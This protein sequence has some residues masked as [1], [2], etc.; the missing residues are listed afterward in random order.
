MK[1]VKYALIL[2]LS[3]LCQA[4]Q[5][6]STP[7]AVPDVHASTQG[8]STTQTIQDFNSDP[9]VHKLSVK[10]NWT[11]R[12][13]G[14]SSAEAVLLSA[15]SA[16]PLIAQICRQ[17]E[18]GAV[19]EVNETSSQTNSSCFTG[20]QYSNGRL[21][22]CSRSEGTNN[23]TVIHKVTCGH[24]AV[25]LAGRTDRCEGRV[26]LW[27]SG[28]WGTVC[29]DQWDLRDADVACAQL[30]C[31]YALD[32]TGQGGAV[33]AG[34]GPIHLDEVN[35]TGEE[36]NL[37]ACPAAGGE[38]D[39]GHK[40]DAGIV[41]S[42]KRDVRLSGGLD[43][44]SG[45][46]EVHRNGSWGTVCDNCWNGRLASI[47]CSML[48]C[49]TRPQK[50]S[51]FSPPLK[52]NSGALYFY[53][54]D[55]KSQSQSLWD[56]KEFINMQHLCHGSKAS[57][58]ICG[59]SLG[60]PNISTDSVAEMSNWTTTPALTVVS[61]AEPFSPSPELLS[62]IALAV[63]LFVFI[64]TNTVLCCLYRRRHAF[65]FQQ[66]LSGQR[67]P[68]SDCPQNKYEGAVDLVKVTT[69]PVRDLATPSSSHPRGLWNQLS[70]VDSTSVDTDY[71][72]YDPSADP[73]APLTTFRNSQRYRTDVNPLMK[74]SG[75]DSLFEEGHECTNGAMG[76]FSSCPGDPSDPQ[77]ARVS[78]IS[79]DSFDSSST[80]SGE[81]Y[82]NVTHLNNGYV[83]VAADPGQSAVENNTFDRSTLVGGNEHQFFAGHTT[84]L[85]MS[86]DDDD[87]HI[88]SPVSP[89]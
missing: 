82:E 70:S 52:H 19:Y 41:C 30:G 25:R 65:L 37:W 38:S 1:L 59:G 87:G 12:M 14:N 20:C 88:Y 54:C 75:L 35:C 47:V 39:C 64:I 48:G 79:V 61:P 9:L 15:R 63:L 72:Q 44:C 53:F 50:V 10:C 62:T 45:V 3:C 86:S 34:S 32:V 73:S 76:A 57:G 36:E 67:Q 22:N 24:S 85:E 28:R 27:R 18:C 78:K 16:P 74:P 42:E 23:C 21:Q 71:E 4:S 77:Y 40:E 60:F 49:G 5:N 8:N 80:S 89:D 83:P 31:G 7:A 29:D 84:N 51:Q 2:Q 68:S 58:V 55:G 46:V 11:L 13:P 26:E 69:G 33:P 56:C 17:L 66:K 81:D 43:R 6:A